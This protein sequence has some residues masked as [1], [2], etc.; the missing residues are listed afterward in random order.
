M[1]TL[2]E[3]AGDVDGR[4]EV[5]A[6]DLSYAYRYVL[7]AEELSEA[8]R[9]DDALAWAERGI[10]AFEET[11]HHMRGDTRLDDVALAAYVARGRRA[12]VIDLVWRRFAERPVLASYERLKRWSEAVGGGGPSASGPTRSSGRAPTGRRRAGRSH[13]R[14]PTSRSGSGQ[15][16]R[17]AGAAWRETMHQSIGDSTSSSCIR[18][19]ATGAHAN[20]RPASTSTRFPFSRSREQPRMM[21]ATGIE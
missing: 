18:G 9:D 14:C 19:T 12:E 17:A 8:G 20:G 11:D 13:G 10:A 3:L 15:D 7:I 5:M 1:E 4:V 2:A 6:R 16:R 21:R